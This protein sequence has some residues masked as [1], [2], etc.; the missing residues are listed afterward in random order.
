MSEPNVPEIPF[1]K[2]YLTKNDTAFDLANRID[3]VA[4][5]LISVVLW[6]TMGLRNNM[7]IT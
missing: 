2:I 6:I 3:A 1:R 7:K 4:N 5:T